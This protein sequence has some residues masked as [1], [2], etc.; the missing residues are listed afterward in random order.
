MSA[1]VASL[2]FAGLPDPALSNVPNVVMSP[3]GGLT[4]TVDVIAGDGPVD[5]S[6][7]EI[8]FSTEVDNLIC[9]CVGQ[10]HTNRTISAFSNALGAADF[11]ISGGG[12]VDSSLVASPPAVQVFATGQL[13]G[14]VGVV[15]PDVVDGSGA[16]AT[17]PG[18]WD[19]LGVCNVAVGDA[20]FHT[21]PIANSVYTFCTDMNSDNTVSLTDA[22]LITNDIANAASCSAQ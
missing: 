10:D 14:Q 21:S 1:T 12:C 8:V 19:P 3:S 18:G 11:N 20:V 15:S 13:L 2:S 17:D 5:S 9:W 6:L 22:V 7:V 16:V 4:Y